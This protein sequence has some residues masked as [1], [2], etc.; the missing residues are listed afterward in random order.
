MSRSPL[1]HFPFLLIVVA[2]LFFL[3]LFLFALIQVGIITV[4]FSKLG[5][6]SGQAILILLATLLGSS[7]N[8]PLY[9]R[10]TN[11]VQPELNLSRFWRHYRNPLFMPNPARGQKQT[12][13]VNIGGCLIP[14]F[15][16]MYFLEQIGLT[17]GLALSLLAVTL[18]TYK[19][20]KPVSGVGIG[21]PF[22]LPPLITVLAVWI[23]A[24]PE[25]SAQIAYISGSLG[26]LLGADV[27]H[28]LNAK[29]SKSL[30][31]PLL[32]IGGAG[33]FDGIFLT[34]I[35]AVLLA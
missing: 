11:F 34:G 4:A 8:I 3:L 1:F 7:I 14:V 21:I 16:S 24:R 31:S 13:A 17:W 29:T 9:S 30:H 15:L 18:I 10:K 27:L 28:L 19:L 22:L 5:L 6:T 23:L 12:I 35:L 33:T 20:A 32:S 2:L 26:T 25:Y